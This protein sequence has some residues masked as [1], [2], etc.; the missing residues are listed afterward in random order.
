[1]PDQQDPRPL[2]KTPA[3]AD[4]DFGSPPPMTG[5]ADHLSRLSSVQRVEVEDRIEAFERAWQKGERPAIAEHLPAD[6]LVRR[7]VLVELVHIDLELRSKAGEAARI[8]SYLKQF[9]ELVNDSE[10]FA[11]I[12]RVD[13]AED[14][15]ERP[16]PD[17]GRD[18]VE[19]GAGSTRTITKGEI[20]TVPAIPGQTIAP[21]SGPES[22]APDL[23]GRFGRYQII[24]V[25]GRGDMGTVYL[26]E[27]SQLRRQVALKT[28][29]F[30]HDPTGEQLERFY[31][32]AQAAAT[33]RHANICPVHDVGQIDGKH[34]ISMS[35][36]KGRPLSAFTRSTESQPERQILLVV[37]KL[38]QALQEAHDHGIVHRDLKPANIMVDEKGEPI[39]TDFGLARQVQPTDDIRLTQSG[40]MLG[41][42]A[43]MSPEQIDGKPD[44]IGPPT[45][46]YSLGVILYELLT[47]QL[48]FRGSL[49]SVL[50]QIATQPVTPPSQLRSDLDPRIDAVCIKMM[51]KAPADRFASLSAV[52]DELETILRNPQAKS[53]KGVVFRR[54]NRWGWVRWSALACGLVIFGLL[55][56][57]I[58]INYGKTVVRI[59]IM[60]PDAEVALKGPTL[61]IK[62][63]KGLST[64]EVK[65]EPGEKG[66]TISHGGLSFTTRSFTL[67]KGDKK[68][69][70]ISVINSDVVAKLGDEI[71]GEGSLVKPS[72]S[73]P[74]Q[75]DPKITTVNGVPPT[76]SL[77]RWE[78]PAFQQ[79]VKEVAVM[80]AEGQV[81]A[82]VKKLREL[83]P[84]FDGKVTGWY[85][86]Q[87]TPVIEAGVVR[88][89]GFS[90][91][92][93]TDISPIRA[94]TGLR[95][96]GCSGQKLTDLTPLSG[97]RLECLYCNDNPITDI[98][99]LKNLPLK[100]LY[101]S[102]STLE[103]ISVLKGMKLEVLFLALEKLKEI[104]ALSG[105]PLRRLGIDGTQVADLS[106]LKGMPLQDLNCRSTLV[107]DLSPLRGM[108]LTYLDCCP[109][110]VSDLSPLA[111]MKLINFRF[112]PKNIT[113]GM[114]AI[115][116]MKS[117]QVIGTGWSEEEQFSPEVFWKKYDAGEFGN[118]RR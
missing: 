20:E 115:R 22:N 66:L 99:P 62:T 87:G 91:D 73:N 84:G 100:E 104:S 2:A 39:I 29:H 13:S 1:M 26:A 44:K 106:P 116:Q 93:V 34:F 110:Q 58:V 5:P 31:R 48:P 77:A 75:L 45:D 113:K 64:E 61:T 41:S 107:S 23:L 78:N 15:S 105:M 92:D 11:E 63:V 54:W 7:S 57:V 90:T 32:E 109:S 70:T 6:P 85:Q 103:D 65:V 96:L 49:T 67:N 102:N 60:D 33:L 114:D 112:V 72:S 16:A 25:L 40:M 74:A 27:D 118:V 94:L 117:F 12:I 14:K 18:F 59:E 80:P 3:L 36:I 24:K 108:P 82:V 10:C 21:R 38:A 17:A 68:T 97:L 28:P 83:N 46:Q 50:T 56:G 81:E 35:Y 51:A 52:A 47:G 86:G 69:V 37:C 55:L 101:F 30:E 4:S 9:P 53:T 76:K 95:R 42:P 71:L 98:S 19:A 43:Y 88:E 89:V 111:G 8:E 79:W